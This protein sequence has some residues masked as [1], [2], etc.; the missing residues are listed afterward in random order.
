MREHF[1]AGEGLEDQCWGG[2]VRD[3]LQPKLGGSLE[4]GTAPSTQAVSPM[5]LFIFFWAGIQ[6]SHAVFWPAQNVS[7]QIFYA[8]NFMTISKT[9]P[10]VTIY[11][12][13]IES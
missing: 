13:A 4:L 6:I 1:E 8:S 9:T 5:N 2:D 10:F 7:K 11:Y 12:I 3:Q